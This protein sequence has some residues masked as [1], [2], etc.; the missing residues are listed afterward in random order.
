[1]AKGVL[2]ISSDSKWGQKNQNPKK[3]LWLPAKPKKIPGQKKSNLNQKKM[4]LQHTV[5][6]RK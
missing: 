2:H 1:M 4:E 3:S 5:K 6:F